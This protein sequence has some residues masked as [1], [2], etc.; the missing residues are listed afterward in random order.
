VETKHSRRVYIYWGIALVLL[1]ALGTFC[2]AV[3]VPV[4]QVRKA[5][6]R[7]RLYKLDQRGH[8]SFSSFAAEEV[9]GLG[10]AN[11]AIRN[12][13]LYTRLP[14]RLAPY[15]DISV[16]LL[17]C[18][19]QRAV[20]AL[21]GLLSD[22][23][24]HV[25]YHAARGLG[26][27]GDKRAIASLEAVLNDQDGAV[28]QAARLAINDIRH[29]SKPFGM[30]T[31]WPAR[32]RIG[33]FREVTDKRSDT[34]DRLRTRVLEIFH[35]ETKLV[36]LR[37]ILNQPWTVAAV[38][39]LGDLVTE[40]VRRGISD[41]EGTLGWGQRQRLLKLMAYVGSSYDG[42]AGMRAVEKLDDLWPL[43]EEEASTRAIRRSKQ[44]LLNALHSHGSPAFMTNGFWKQYERTG[45]GYLFMVE[46]GDRAALERLK[47]LQRKDH[48]KTGSS[49]RISLDEAV[50]IIEA[51]LKYPEIRRIWPVGERLRKAELLLFVEQHPE[52]K[53]VKW[54]KR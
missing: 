21:I 28:A 45:D 1:L 37:R 3:V 20:P 31:S 42:K 48:W 35:D 27:I 44:T 51:S 40:D 9:E 4:W 47:K 46:K 17:S 19:G 22:E 10:G 39:S 54:P 43:M 7:C 33:A 36:T 26:R 49:R 15:H 41:G 38:D 13:L 6:I 12:I 50:T 24:E 11:G 2:W 30:G 25:R 53:K 16:E 14:K 23:D 32:L 8:R 18:C 52:F 5:V 34:E 29:G